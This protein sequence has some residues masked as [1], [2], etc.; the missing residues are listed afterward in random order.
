MLCARHLEN[1]ELSC[2]L[3]QS[4]FFVNPISCFV[5]ISFGLHFE[6]KS[7][8][9]KILDIYPEFSEAN[10]S[11]F[12]LDQSDHPTYEDHLVLNS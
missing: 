6:I 1:Q 5:R 4:K 11:I 2:I 3:P 10:T 9:C 8:S 12:M 7:I